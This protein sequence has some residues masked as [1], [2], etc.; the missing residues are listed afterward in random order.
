MVSRCNLPEL[1]YFFAAAL[2]RSAQ[3]FFIRSDS[4]LRPAAVRWLPA[5]CRLPELSSAYLRFMA[6]E[7]FFLAAALILLVLGGVEPVAICVV[8]GR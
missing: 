3:R 8:A 2:R 4:L 1:C 5:L 6:S 7:I